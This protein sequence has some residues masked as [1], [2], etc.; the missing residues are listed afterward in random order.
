MSGFGPFVPFG[1]PIGG[2]SGTTQTVVRAD[3]PN[4]SY[5]TRTIVRPARGGPARGRGPE[6]EVIAD[7]FSTM[8][9]NIVR[10]HYNRP[11]GSNRDEDYP[12]EGN[13]PPLPHGEEPRLNPRDA[14]VPQAGD[15][16]PVP[17]IQT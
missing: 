15:A 16:V 7:L 1:A 10:D 8:L 13:V 14:A 5:V 2:A 4:F 3:G 9:R 17:D 11:E 12:M 6:E